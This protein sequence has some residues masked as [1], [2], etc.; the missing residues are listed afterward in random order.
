MDRH[1]KPLSD[2]EF[3]LFQKLIYRAAGIYLSAVKKALIEARLSRRVRDLGLASFSEYYEYLSGENS[4][5]ELGEML[6]RIS[7]NETHFFREPRQFEF[8][9]QQVFPQWRAQAMRAA[10]SK[11]VRV[12]S[13]GCSTGEEPYSIGMILL[14]HFPARSGWQIEVFASDLSRRVLQTATAAV[15]PIGKAKQIPPKYLKQFML[16][17][18]G[19]HAGNMKAAAELTAV[20]RFEQLNLH[21]GASPWLKNFDLIFCR[22]V[23]IYFD[24]RSRAR[25]IHQLVDSLLPGG[26][27][28]VGHAESLTGMTKHLQYAAPTVYRRAAAQRSERVDMQ[29]RGANSGT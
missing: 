5:A 24:A 29:H 9:E 15:W 19:A 2:R 25:V 3:V 28:L 22:N 4:G 18:T 12:W 20:V 8:L 17:G 14:D 27:L 16:R 6:D 23:L 11:R 10:R 26:Y 1:R 13:A 21:D 7:T